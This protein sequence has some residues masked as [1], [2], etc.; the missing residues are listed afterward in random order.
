MC[1]LSN[2]NIVCEYNIVILDD[3]VIE[4]DE[5]FNIILESDDPSRCIILQENIAITI[6]DDGMTFHQYTYYVYYK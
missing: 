3:M 1:T 2:L 5:S 6:R 4:D